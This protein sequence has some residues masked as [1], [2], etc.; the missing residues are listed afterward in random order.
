MSGRC[1]GAA[2]VFCFRDGL[3]CS[4]GERGDVVVAAAGQ[5][6]PAL[7]TAGHLDP[8]APATAIVPG[9]AGGI[10]SRRAQFWTAPGTCTVA[11]G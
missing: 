2:A 7:L 10:V 11:L 8:G 9:G 6:T 4:K 1:H 5:E 3:S